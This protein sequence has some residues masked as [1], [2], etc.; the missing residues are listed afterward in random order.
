MYEAGPARPFR[1][2]YFSV[3]G[4]PLD[5]TNKP[6]LM[7]DH[8]IMR[9]SVGKAVQVDYIFSLGTALI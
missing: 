2:L 5:S 7:G 3:K 6:A 8:R 9:V 1:F 4:T